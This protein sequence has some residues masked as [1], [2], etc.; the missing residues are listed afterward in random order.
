MIFKNAL[1]CGVF[2]NKIHKL[3]FDSALYTFA[4][5]YHNFTISRA[6][7]QEIINYKKLIYAIKIISAAQMRLPGSKCPRRPLNIKGFAKFIADFG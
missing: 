3:F 2:E 4:N 1:I 5:L 7:I 6:A